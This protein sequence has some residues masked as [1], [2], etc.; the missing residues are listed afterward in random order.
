ML[1]DDNDARNI[2]KAVVLGALHGPLNKGSTPSS[3]FSNQ[4]M[5]TFAAKPRYASRFWSERNMN[6][7][8]SDVRAV[9]K[10]RLERL[11]IELPQKLYGSC[12]LHGDSRCSSSYSSIDDKVDYV[13]TSP[14]YY[15]MRT[16]EEDQWIRLWFLGG[17]EAPVYKNSRQLTHNGTEAFAKDLSL[18]WDR[19]AEVANDN[20]LMVVRF[21]S[22]GSKKADHKQIMKES[23]HFSN[24][25]WKL[26][27]SIDAGKS[28]DGRRQSLSMGVN[29]TS[30]SISENDFYIRFA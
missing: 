20:L 21:G 19:V 14:P 12:V 18:V 5:R 23:L 8:F 26:T 9:I 4:M 30:S 2:L 22:I 13:V 24:V 17:S 29:S 10:K 27:K 15:G 16:Y 7:P 25:D 3:Y 6:A 11:V 28:S 1:K